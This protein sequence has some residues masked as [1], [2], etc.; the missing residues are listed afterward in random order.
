M[1]RLVKLSYQAGQHKPE[2][3]KQHELFVCSASWSPVRQDGERQVRIR[4][5]VRHHH[6]DPGS[7]AGDFLRLAVH[8]TSVAGTR[9]GFVVRTGSLLRNQQL[10]YDPWLPAVQA[11]FRH[12]EA[13]SLTVLGR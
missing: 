8:V 3:R 5:L 4:V 12:Q 11:S 6:A 2:E 13:F 9:A 10:H 7:D 1:P